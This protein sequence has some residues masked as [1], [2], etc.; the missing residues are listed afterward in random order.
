MTTS[1]YK[2]FVPQI[3]LVIALGFVLTGGFV[4]AS[5]AITRDNVTE[6]GGG[7]GGIGGGGG[8]GGTTTECSDGVDNDGNG[9]ID[10]P[11]D[12]GCTS[13]G[14][15]TEAGYTPPT[16][17]GDGV[18]NDGNGLTDYP[19][20]LGC[21]AA[22][23]TTESG[24]VTQCTDNIDN[25]GNGLKDY[26]ADQ[27]CSSAGDISETG[28]TPP[29]APPPGVIVYQTQ[30]KRDFLSKVYVDQAANGGIQETVAHGTWPAANV[31]S[32]QVTL[33]GTRICQLYDP[34]AFPTQWSLGG[35]DSPSNNNMGGW[36][37]STWK[38]SSANSYG[39]KR[40]NYIT[41]RTNSAPDTSL[42]AQADGV[43]GTSLSVTSGTP[44]SLTWLSRYGSIRKGTMS[45]VNFDLVEVVAAHWETVT[46]LV[47]DPGSGDGG[48]E[49]TTTSIVEAPR[50]SLMA[51]PAG[52]YFSS[53]QVWIP[54]GTRSLPFGG[55][56]VV[57]PTQTTTYTYRGTNANG[58]SQSS[59]TVNVTG[60]V[61]PQC[62]DLIDNDSDGRTDFPNDPDC[63]GADDDT[64]I[65]PPV[66][67]QCA[68]LIDNDGNGL[69]DYLQDP[70]CSS[71]DDTT[72]TPDAAAPTVTFTATPSSIAPDGYTTLTWS[73]TNATSCNPSGDGFSTGGAVSGSDQVGP[74]AAPGPY[75]YAISCSGPGGVKGA[76][77]SVAITSPTATMS[78]SPDRVTKNGSVGVTWTT[79]QCGTVS[80]TKNGT[81]FSTDLSGTNV[82]SGPITG[83]TVFRVSCDG[84]SA[85]AS[86]IVNVV[87]GFDEF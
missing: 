40:Y 65:T 33:S 61:L 10:Y 86:V 7:G 21:S 81:A 51:L 83:Q 18:D 32:S 47:C 24:Y 66:V 79:T 63:T 62:S 84:A 53:Q 85:L 49:E 54:E 58:T 77:A 48:W 25:D 14:D 75:N 3:L 52:C 74:L 19:S 78:A 35:F 56:A 87:P 42:I 60:A 76:S 67:P 57:T 68:D 6:E 82:S 20:D 69:T 41:C 55:T 37:G 2:S 23:D 1:I 45:G 39:N 64:E 44:V 71:A 16:Q 5:G 15:A 43:S 29:P 12:L 22:S 30:S 9:R 72:E 59:V 73:T 46:D 27:G 17:C 11:S 26:P 50:R 13:T 36:T 34:T 4:P 70:G 8:G 80:V 31:P 38:R 28:Y